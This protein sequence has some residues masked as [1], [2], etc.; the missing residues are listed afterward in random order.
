MN[1]AAFAI[2]STASYVPE[3]LRARVAAATMFRMLAV[4]PRIDNA[5][6][7]GRKP[8]SAGEQL[9]DGRLD[10]LEYRGH[11]FSAQRSICLPKRAESAG[12]ARL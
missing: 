11:N 8:V 7:Q 5:S 9:D 2:M 3:Y 10:I 6:D 4:K 1:E 12:A